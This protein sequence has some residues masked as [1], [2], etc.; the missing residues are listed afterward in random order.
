MPKATVGMVNHPDLKI[1]LLNVQK[2]SPRVAPLQNQLWQNLQVG[3]VGRYRKSY[4]WFFL[5][6]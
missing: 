1:S 4:L 3:K 2:S 5:Q 6:Q